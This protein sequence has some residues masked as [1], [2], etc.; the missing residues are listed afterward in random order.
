MSATPPTDVAAQAREAARFRALVIYAAFLL[1]MGVSVSLAVTG[2]AK[3]LILV[4]V[5][6]IDVFVVVILVRV[7]QPSTLT[8]LSSRS[9]DETWP[10]TAAASLFPGLLERNPRLERRGEMTGTVTISAS[11]VQWVPSP[12]CV[13]AFGAT[14]FSWDSRWIGYARHLRGLGGQVQ[15]TLTNPSEAMPV[16]IWMRR[17]STFRIP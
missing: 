15:L 2:P 16:T 3:V 4:A 17:A 7:P 6:A 11:G 13:R 5:V 9:D 8:A 12:Q 1:V 14:P 10:A